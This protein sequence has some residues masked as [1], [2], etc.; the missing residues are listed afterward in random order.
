MKLWKK[1][2]DLV[3]EDELSLR[4][5]LKLFLRKASIM[6]II[7]LVFAGVGMGVAWFIAEQTEYKLQ[8]VAFVEGVIV[9]VIGLLASMKGNPSGLGLSSWGAKSSPQINFWNLEATVQER[10]STDYYN[11]FRNHS[12][13]EFLFGRVTF[14]LG[15]IF[16]VA[17]SILFL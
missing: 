9:I 16:L 13:V 17:I 8:D 2:M 15:G 4:D 11:N 1:Q 14:I 7:G 12:V 3:E 6:S 5:R 10:E